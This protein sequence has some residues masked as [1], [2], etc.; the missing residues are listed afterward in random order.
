MPLA[1][2]AVRAIFLHYKPMGTGQAQYQQ[3]SS[4]YVCMV[5]GQ[6]SVSVAQSMR[7]LPCKHHYQSHRI[8][9]DDVFSQHK[10]TVPFI[11]VWWHSPRYTI[12]GALPIYMPN[13]LIF[14][15][16]VKLI[17]VLPHSKLFTVPVW[18]LQVLDQPQKYRNWH[19]CLKLK[20]P[21]TH[22]K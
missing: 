9:Q 5:K 7:R 19:Q 18:A 21:P 17:L 20:P 3:T 2:E 16:N 1:H 4:V 14:A 12:F 13:T 15:N 8:Q 6:H 22:A 10:I 11:K